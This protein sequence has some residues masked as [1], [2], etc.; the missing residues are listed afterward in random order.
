MD[1]RGGGEKPPLRVLPPDERFQAREPP[2]GQ[3]DGRLV[4]EAEVTVGDR[5]LKRPLQLE[6]LDRQEPDVLAEHLDPVAARVLGPVHRRVGVAQQ[7]RGINPLA[8]D[9]HA[10]A[11]RHDQVPAFHGDGRGHGPT[12]AVGEPQGFVGVVYLRQY[13]E[14]V[15]PEAG[16]GVFGP[17]GIAERLPDRDEHGV[18]GGVVH[19]VVDELEPVEVHEHDG[20]GRLAAFDPG[21][22]QLQAIDEQRPVREP[23]EGVV[24]G[25][26]G[27]RLLGFPLSFDERAPLDGEADEVTELD[28]EAQLVI[29]EVGHIRAGPDDETAAFAE[30]ELDPGVPVGRLGHGPVAGDRVPSG[31]EDRRRRGTDV[32]G[33]VGQEPADDLLGRGGADEVGHR[34]LEPL[35]VRPPP[36]QPQHGGRDEPEAER[37]GHQ[38]GDAAGQHGDPGVGGQAGGPHDDL[39]V[40]PGGGGRQHSHAPAGRLSLTLAGPPHAD[41]D[42][43]EE[44]GPLE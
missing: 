17:E 35:V 24:Q 36:P 42:E 44:E 25:L 3:P 40:E 21:Q 31:V 10:D 23:G 6:L 37:P 12:Q 34:L 5:L 9:D 1:E 26:L 33:D 13:D 27:Q 32:V 43:R 20:D 41:G 16:H 18:A 14:L 38:N 15:T 22:G 4:D 30:A 7:R 19:P 29:A 8:G 11:G 2:V 39:H 28:Q